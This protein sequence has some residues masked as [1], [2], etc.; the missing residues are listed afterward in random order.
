MSSSIERKVH[1]FVWGVILLAIIGVSRGGWENGWER[2]F[3]AVFASSIT[4]GVQLVAST[5]SDSARAVLSATQCG[6]QDFTSGMPVGTRFSSPPPTTA[7][8]FSCTAK[9][10]S[11]ALSGASRAEPAFSRSKRAAGDGQP[12]GALRL[13]GP[14]HCALYWL[15]PTA[16]CAALERIGGIVFIGDSLARQLAQGLALILS[17]NFAVG[18][19][20][21]AGTLRFEQPAELVWER[22]ACDATFGAWYGCHNQPITESGKEFRSL[23]P[24]WS[25]PASGF[26]YFPFWRGA[27]QSIDVRAHLNSRRGLRAPI[28]VLEIGP[29][30]ADEWVPENAA[31][32]LTIKN[33]AA[34]A[35]AAK[36][37]LVCFL[38][39]APDDE[40]KPPQYVASQGDAAARAINTRVRKLCETEGALI[41]DG[42][43]LTKSAWSRDGTHYEARINAMLSQALL[44]LVAIAED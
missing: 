36:A 14:A 38:A 3:A 2:E 35:S 37:R 22:C 9:D 32:A 7:S 16:A 13:G 28:I 12:D 5:S 44:N 11:V 19:L 29:G 27:W 25:L 41:L 42:Y 23:C 15:N 17:G 24:Q 8:N 26:H 10:L 34:D 33:A 43:S 20:L 18:S 4:A 30:W 39:L 6:G 21:A 31:I 1:Y 40:K